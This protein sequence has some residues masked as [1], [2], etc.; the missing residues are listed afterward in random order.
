L[1]RTFDLPADSTVPVIER[2]DTGD[3]WHVP[4]GF[5]ADLAIYDTAGQLLSENH[6][7]F[8]DEEVQTFLTSVYPLAPVK[9]ANAVVLTADEATAVKNLQ[10][11]ASEGGAYSHELLKATPG[12]DKPEFE[13][14]ASVP[15]SSNYYIRVSA[16]SGKAAHQ[17]RLTIDGQEASLEKY[18][19]LNPN[20]HLTRDV[21]STPDISWY[22]GWTARLNKGQHHLVFSVPGDGAT[23]DLL[24]DAVALQR[25]QE[26]PDPFYIPGIRDLKAEAEVGQ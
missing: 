20:E 3:A 2:K 26:L 13:F 1:T 8:T 16:N 19:T 9:P 23:P 7:D 18:E 12:G 14:T 17:F 24:F 6:Y 25:Y 11:Q 22:P 4:G 10:R 15:E 5:F 21:Y